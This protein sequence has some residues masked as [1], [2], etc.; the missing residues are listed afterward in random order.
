MEDKQFRE[1]ESA[2]IKCKVSGMPEPTITW[3]KDGHELATTERHFLASEDQVLVIT[4][5]TVDDEG[6]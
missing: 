6:R 4:G 5:F 3:Y 1:G 2:V